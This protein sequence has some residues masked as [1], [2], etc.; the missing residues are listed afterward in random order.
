MNAV[1][2]CDGM[3]NIQENEQ[4]IAIHSNMNKKYN[5]E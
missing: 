1:C 4:N 5:I 2:S 3:L